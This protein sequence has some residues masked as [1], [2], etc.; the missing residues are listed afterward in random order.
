MSKDS[1]KVYFVLGEESGDKLGADL[2]P[3]LMN[4]AEK[5]GRE[6]QIVGLAGTNL[7]KLGVRSLFDI[8]DIA[9]MGIWRFSPDCQK[10]CG[11]S[12]K[13]FLTL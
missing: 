6:L 1:L 12:I 2:A 4:R 13:R 3:A 7:Q 9:V 10:S 11:A 5:A 8:E